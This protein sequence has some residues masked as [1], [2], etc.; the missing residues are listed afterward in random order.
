MG[1]AWRDDINGA[2]SL[3]CNRH[4]AQ[5]RPFEC[6]EVERVSP[7]LESLPEACLRAGTHQEYIEAESFADVANQI[8]T[9]DVASHWEKLGEVIPPH[10]KSCFSCEPDPDIFIFKLNTVP[11]RELRKFTQV[12]YEKRVARNL[13]HCLHRDRQYW[14]IMNMHDDM[15]ALWRKTQAATVDGHGPDHNASDCWVEIVCMCRGSADGLFFKRLYDS[16]YVRFQVLLPTVHTDASSCERRFS[17]CT[18]GRTLLCIWL[19]RTSQH[20]GLK[21]NIGGTLV[22]FT[23]LRSGRRC[24]RPVR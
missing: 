6:T 10:L 9:G 7:S 22:V 8:A 23:S 24:W 11:F 14:H 13:K 1:E 4:R 17:R 5:R 16:Y 3:S 19:M 12:L 20:A 15:P 18:C 2:C 21:R